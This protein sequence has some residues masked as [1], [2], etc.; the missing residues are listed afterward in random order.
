[1]RVL[2]VASYNKGRFASF[3]SEQAEALSRHGC[4]V[5]F[6]GVQGKGVL[7]YLRNLPL[8]KDAIRSF[9]PNL[10]HAHYG[11]CGLLA[12]LQHEMPVV[13][14]FHGSDLNEPFVRPFSLLAMRRADQSVF[15][16]KT[17]MGNH[18]GVLLP[19]GVDLPTEVMPVPQGVFAAGKKHVLFA[20]AFSNQ[21]KDAVLAHKVV[22]T[23]D[24]VQLIELQG[25]SRNEVTALMQSADAL[26]V[27]SKSEGSPQ[28]IKEALVCGLP[29]VSVNVGD[30]A[31][32]VDGV[33]GCFV[34]RTREPEELRHLLL[35]ALAFGARTKGRDRIIRDGLTNDAVARQ[36]I[37][38]YQRITQ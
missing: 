37:T 11:L 27:T 1:M 32:R 24:T 17:M 19:C 3:V 15:V 8:L 4:H 9:H 31:E 18:R 23:L 26:L 2:I 6:F 30:V 25:Y 5:S 10:I 20:G 22:D 36:L 38:I 7:G 21:V 12:T 34:A 29:I 35:Q 13:V 28:V 14:T 16:S 33:D